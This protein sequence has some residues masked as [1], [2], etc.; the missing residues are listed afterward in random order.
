MQIEDIKKQLEN[1]IYT[2][3]LSLQAINALSEHIEKQNE[4]IAEL[5]KE[6]EDAVND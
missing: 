5:S 3:S 6:T 1:S 2:N 4:K